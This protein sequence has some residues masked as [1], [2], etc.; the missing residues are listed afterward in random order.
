MHILCTDL[1]LSRQQ[2]HDGCAVGVSKEKNIWLTI[3]DTEAGYCFHEQIEAQTPHSGMETRQRTLPVHCGGHLD[4]KEVDGS[5]GSESGMQTKVTVYVFKLVCRTVARNRAG[6]LK[7][8]LVR[9]RLL[10]N[11]LEH[12]CHLVTVSLFP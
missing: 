3:G 2:V 8:F 1:V 10:Q 11:A 12:D 4:M 9:V 5:D 6:C 7:L